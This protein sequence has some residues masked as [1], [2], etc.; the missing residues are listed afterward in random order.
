MYSV[1]PPQPATR[2]ASTPVSYFNTRAPE[3][4]GFGREVENLITA[5]KTQPDLIANVIENKLCP[6][7]EIGAV[8][9]NGCRT[10]ERQVR[11]GLGIGRN[12]RAPKQIKA[13]PETGR[14]FMGLTNCLFSLPRR[15]VM[16]GKLAIIRKE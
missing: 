9:R 5:G 11:I 16:P 10:D 3:R 8:A 6:V 15:H 4:R 7:G 13:N 14:A 12:H 2:N 1:T